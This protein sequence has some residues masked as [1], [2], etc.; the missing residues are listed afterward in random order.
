MEVLALWRAPR[1]PVSYCR[2]ESSVAGPC[3][4]TG[5][6]QTQSCRL[7][8][9]ISDAY[10]VGGGHHIAHSIGRARPHP[11][12]PEA[13]LGNL[14]PQALFQS[15]ASFDAIQNRQV[16]SQR[17]LHSVCDRRRLL[18]SQSAASP[19]PWRALR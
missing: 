4:R 10:T 9:S 15:R 2:G 11:R 17:L 5:E 16:L 6:T 19:S 1:T 7:C 8:R 13:R 3:G 18:F 14:A 12:G